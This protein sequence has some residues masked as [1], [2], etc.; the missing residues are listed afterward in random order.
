MPNR[1]DTSV[2]AMKPPITTT[3]LAA[4][5]GHAIDETQLIGT[6]EKHHHPVTA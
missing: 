1:I 4:M 3:L 5:E 2:E 6:Y